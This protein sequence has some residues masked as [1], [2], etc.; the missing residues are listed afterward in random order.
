[1]Q[2][3]NISGAMKEY[4]WGSPSFIQKLLEQE[5]D[6]KSNSEDK[7]VG[8]LW[9]G[10]HP[11]GP[12]FTQDGISLEILLKKNPSLLG[13]HSSFPFLLKVMA[14]EKPLS[15]QVHPTT[16]QAI[17]GYKREENKRKIVHSDVLNYQ[18]SNE[19]AEMLYALSPMTVMLGF[20]HVAKIQED[21]KRLLGTYYQDYFA[22]CEDISSIFH[23]L[24]TIEKKELSLLIEQYK[25]NLNKGEEIRNSHPNFLTPKEIA[26]TAIEDYNVDPGVFAPYLLNVV[27]LEPKEA[28][29]LSPQIVHAYVKGEGIELMTNSDN[30]L[31]AGLTNKHMDVEELMKIMIAKETKVMKLTTSKKISGTHINT[32]NNVFE[33][34]VLE[35]GTYTINDN[36]LSILL[37]TQGCATIIS[38]EET[39]TLTKGMSVYISPTPNEY[40]IATDGIVFRAMGK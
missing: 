25:K 31:R 27:Y 36:V 30:I 17:E 13:K 18:D 3:I 21:L 40:T 34:A 5:N 28:I 20:K 39:V 10:T 1:M 6:K 38:K 26:L 11:N 4:P 29:Y 33:L 7:L 16:Q 15:I 22:T 32:P 19:K 2:I 23:T 12:S 24:Y 8:E 35:K 37:V 9:F 14:I